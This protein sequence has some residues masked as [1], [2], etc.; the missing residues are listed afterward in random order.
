MDA[1]T[2]ALVVAALAVI[3][4]PFTAWLRFRVAAKNGTG[5]SNPADLLDLD[6]ERPFNR[7]DDGGVTGVIGAGQTG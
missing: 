2:G 1:T 3:S 4:T 5:G 7:P 6:S